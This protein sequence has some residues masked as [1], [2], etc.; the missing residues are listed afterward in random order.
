MSEIA[1]IEQLE[2]DLIIKNKHIRKLLTDI[3]VSRLHFWKC[4]L[5]SII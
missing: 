5:F 1:A 2:K 4:L 3:K